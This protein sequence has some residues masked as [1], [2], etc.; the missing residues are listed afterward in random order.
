MNDTVQNSKSADSAVYQI[1]NVRFFF[2]RYIYVLKHF[3]QHLEN[4]IFQVCF[5]HYRKV[6]SFQNFF[7]YLFNNFAFF[8]SSHFSSIHT[9]LDIAEISSGFHRIYNI[10]LLRF[11][12]F[13]CKST[14][15][16]FAS[17]FCRTDRRLKFVQKNCHL[18]N[19]FLLFK[20]LQR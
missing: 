5:R 15:I 14:H 2:H 1:C 17:I 11:L 20:L 7:S 3:F 8:F 9:L 13:H 18:G 10:F 6:C 4:R 12:I 16:D 19:N